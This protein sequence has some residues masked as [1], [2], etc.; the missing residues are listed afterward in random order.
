MNEL[1][2]RRWSGGGRR[3]G[4]ARNFSSS[5]ASS[6]ASPSMILNGLSCSSLFSLVSQRSYASV[7]VLVKG[8]DSKW[9]EP[10]WLFFTAVTIREPAKKKKI[11][12]ARQKSFMSAILPASKTKL[13]EQPSTRPMTPTR[14]TG[15]KLDENTSD[16]F[17][18]VKMDCL[19]LKTNPSRDTQDTLLVIPQTN[20]PS[21]EVVCCSLTRSTTLR[22]TFYLFTRLTKLSC[23]LVRQFL[24]EIQ[25]RSCLHSPSLIL[26]F[27]YEADT[28]AAIWQRAPSE[29]L[30][31]LTILHLGQ[32]EKIDW[33]EPRKFDCRLV[34]TIFIFLWPSAIFTTQPENQILIPD[35]TYFHCPGATLV[36]DTRQEML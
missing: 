34:R 11:R 15:E 35:W 24:L 21:L 5:G 10:L 33:Q 1:V 36:K 12:E 17:Q 22:T 23:P 19:L 20:L 14:E 2:K 27:N 18:S 3:W 16:S 30:G 7:S 4:S 28:K 32:R 31:L 25:E 9:E 29:K 8:V 26:I 6:P 13:R